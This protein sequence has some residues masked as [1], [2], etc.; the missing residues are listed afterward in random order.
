MSEEPR[1]L[2]I[3]Y[4]RF[5]GRCVA[6][7]WRLFVTCF[8]EIPSRLGGVGFSILCSLYTTLGY[9]P[10]PPSLDEAGV[11]RGEA[12]PGTAEEGRS[13]AGGRILCVPGAASSIAGCPRR[14]I[15]HPTAERFQPLSAHCGHLVFCLAGV[16]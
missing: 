12:P 2:I 1:F 4:E 5:T 16:K 13:C 11:A 7:L 6:A 14:Y 10:K 9:F 8:C 15:R 3:L